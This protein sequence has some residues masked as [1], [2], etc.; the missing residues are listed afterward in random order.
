MNTIHAIIWC[1]CDVSSSTNF[2]RPSLVQLYGL[3]HDFQATTPPREGFS[4]IDIVAESRRAINWQSSSRCWAA[5][6]GREYK[7]NQKTQFISAPQS[8]ERQLPDFPLVL[9]SANKWRQNKN[10]F[11]NK[12]FWEKNLRIIPKKNINLN[13][14]CGIFSP[15]KI[16]KGYHRL[17]DRRV[18]ESSTN[19]WVEAGS[20][21]INLIVLAKL[22]IQPMRCNWVQKPGKLNILIPQGQFLLC[23]VERELHK[24]R[25]I[26]CFPCLSPEWTNCSGCS[27]D[28]IQLFRRSN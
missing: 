27:A 8:Y 5:A 28:V 26:I 6:N 22:A 21:S 23:A 7:T 14:F 18:L 16:P 10:K 24:W 15:V 1:F 3:E 12:K 25:Q 11:L 4:Y 17:L 19:S 9:S 2:L 13:F 20:P